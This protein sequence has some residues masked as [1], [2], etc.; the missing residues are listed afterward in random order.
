MKQT[1]FLI[2]LFLKGCKEM[3]KYI[4]V[5]AEKFGYGPIITCLNVVKVLKQKLDKKTKLIFLGTS[6]AK[7]QAI[8]SK[9]FDE[10]IEC[11]TY[12]YHDLSNFKE[13][14]IHACA[15]VSSENQFGAI[16]AKQLNTKMSI[17]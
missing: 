2:E 10:V 13:L 8:S 1:A 6:I 7:E 4:L 5:T 11:K 12:N 17:L 9:L 3:G 14:F 15:I 16:Y